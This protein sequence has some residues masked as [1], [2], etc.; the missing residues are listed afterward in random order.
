MP[1]TDNRY[2][3][4]VERFEDLIAWQKARVLAREI[5]RV[6]D[7]RP[8]SRDFALKN[9]I[10]KAALSVPSNIAEGFER[11]NPREFIYFLKIAKASCGEV[12]SQIYLASDVGYLDEMTTQSLLTEATRCGQVI[13][14]LRASIEARA[15]SPPHSTQHAA[16]GT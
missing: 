15:S 14:R 12:R 16:R 5:Y 4:R 8:F 3:S 13:G 10:R 2:M 1:N 7:M 9:Q 6:S 11:F